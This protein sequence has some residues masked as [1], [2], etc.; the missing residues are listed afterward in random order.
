[1][2]VVQTE[3]SEEEYRLLKERLEK[4]GMSVKEGVRRT[5]LEAL[6]RETAVSSDDPFFQDRSA[7]SGK[8]NVGE[9]HDNYLY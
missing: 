5:I 2:K 8:K 6:D 7:G 9:K 1:M 4:E 3:L